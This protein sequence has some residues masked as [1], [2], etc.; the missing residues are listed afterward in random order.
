[1]KYDYL[2]VYAILASIFALFLVIKKII[3][4]RKEKKKGFK[5]FPIKT[6]KDTLT[7][8]L[9][10]VSYGSYAAENKIKKVNIND[11]LSLF[12]TKNVNSSD[13]IL[14]ESRFNDIEKLIVGIP[15]ICDYK[16]GSNKE[17]VESI[18]PKTYSHK[19]FN[20]SAPELYIKSQ[21]HTINESYKMMENYSKKNSVNYDLVIKL[22]FD[23]GMRSF[24]ITP[25]TLQ[26]IRSDKAIF[27]T[28]EGQ[29]RHPFYSNACTTCNTMYDL[30]MKESHLG[31]HSNIVCDFLAYGS[32]KSMKKYCSII[33]VYDDMNDAWYEK[34]IDSGTKKGLLMGG[35]ISS[36]VNHIDSLFHFVCSYPERMLQLYLRDYM[37]ISSRYIITR[38]FR[39]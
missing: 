7:Y 8:H 32:Q 14:I 30:G 5:P 21:L 13:I 29:H 22:R 20:Y 35:G 38:H 15:R 37:L 10:Y 31:N 4:I 6:E 12:R 23:C 26:Y 11:T 1:M 18:L 16:I 34:N 9:Q 28:N 2:I 27:V 24:L 25:K 19:Y 39:W 33:D 36:R 3:R 17:Y